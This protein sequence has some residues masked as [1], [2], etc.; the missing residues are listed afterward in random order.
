LG[1][2]TI[3]VT[4]V[5]APAKLNMSL[6]ILG[7]RADGYHELVSLMVPVNIQDRLIFS[8][9]SRGIHLSCQ[10]IPVPA[11]EKNLVFRAASAFF[12]RVGRNPS[13]SISLTKN[14]PV[15]AGLGGGSSDAAATLKTLNTMYHHPLGAGELAETALGLGAD[16]PFFLYNIPSIARGVGERLEPLTNWPEFWY[17]VVTPPLSISTAW[18]YGNLK[19]ELTVSENDYIVNP[20]RK[21]WADIGDILQNDLETVTA[22][23]YPVIASM[24]RILMDTGAEGALMSG[25]GPSVFGVFRSEEAARKA[26]DAVSSR[27]EGK[28]FL[29]RNFRNVSFE[30]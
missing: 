23:R 20:L 1:E 4:T 16:V 11:T 17:V 9:V 10:G 14:I 21:D 13:L 19:L 26:K 6:K 7:R 22:A 2:R 8:S 29:A 3:P 12:S 5:E 24:K 15:A 27:A 18:V 28:V 30:R 25:S